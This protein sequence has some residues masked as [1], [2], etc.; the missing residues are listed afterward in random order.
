MSLPY[1]NLQRINYPLVLLTPC[2]CRYSFKSTE[3]QVLRLNVLA[4]INAEAKSS[5]LKGE[6]GNVVG[7]GDREMG[8]T[9]DGIVTVLRRV[10]LLPL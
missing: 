6:I 3:E 4:S 5:R 2:R 1:V 8:G 10:F 9:V 7:R